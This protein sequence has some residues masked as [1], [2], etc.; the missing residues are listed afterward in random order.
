M[1]IGAASMQSLSSR[2]NAAMELKEAEL[3]YGKIAAGSINPGKCKTDHDWDNRQIAFTNKSNATL[4]AAKV[5]LDYVIRPELEGSDDELFFEDDK[6]RRYQMPLEGQN[7]KHDNK[8]VYNLLK[9]ACVDTNGWAWI[10]KSDPAADGRKAWLALVTTHYDGYGELNKC[11]HRAKTELVRLNYKDKKIFPFEKYVTKLKEQEYRV[12]E[13]DKHKAYSK[14]CQVETMLSGMNA[15]DAELEAAKAQIFH[16]MQHS[17]D[18]A[19]EFMS[20]Y[21]SK[22]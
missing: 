1:M 20:A 18:G 19:S 22:Q 11:V 15:K 4:G 10:Q 13:K 16:S 6:V 7:F 8:L 5:P 3:A 21:V 9:A 14:S 17:F 2:D 12:L